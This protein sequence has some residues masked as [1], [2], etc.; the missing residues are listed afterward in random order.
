[1]HYI[2]LEYE[3]DFKQIELIGLTSSQDVLGKLGPL[4]GFHINSIETTKRNSSLKR[5]T[6]RSFCFMMEDFSHTRYKRIHVSAG[7]DAVTGSVKSLTLNFSDPSL[8]K[9][10][11]DVIAKVVKNEESPQR[12]LVV[13]DIIR[14]NHIYMFKLMVI[15]DLSRLEAIGFFHFDYISYYL[16]RKSE[17]RYLVFLQEL[18]VKLYVFV[19]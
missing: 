7:C 8:K 18:D 19:N 5:W 11:S 10:E 1:M 4:M 2:L 15:F 14:F 17:N 9:D 13:N 16:E 12:R 3:E 6:F